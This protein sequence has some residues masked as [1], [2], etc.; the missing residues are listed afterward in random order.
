MGMMDRDWYRDELAQRRR[1]HRR[2]EWRGTVRGVMATTAIMLAALA[3]LPFT[4]TSRCDL[5]G[6]QT[7]PVICWRSSW[8]ALNERVKGNM[9]ATRGF[10]VSTVRV[11]H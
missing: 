8:M 9:A 1:R 7:M 5:D 3:I 10:P 4:L 6:W 2:K 11:G